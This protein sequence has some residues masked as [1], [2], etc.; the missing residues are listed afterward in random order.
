MWH[1]WGKENAHRILAWKSERKKDYLEDLDIIG[2][3]HNNLC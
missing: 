2:R 3:K 1:V